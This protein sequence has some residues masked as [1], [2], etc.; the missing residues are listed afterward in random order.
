MAREQQ[1]H[2]GVTCDRCGKAID[3]GE[4][5]GSGLLPGEYCEGCAAVLG[6]ADCDRLRGHVEAIIDDCRRNRCYANI[7]PAIRFLEE[8]FGVKG[9]A[10]P[11]NDP[12]LRMFRE[13]GTPEAKERLMRQLGDAGL[14]ETIVP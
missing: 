1:G 10:L 7:W 4:A 11:R 3:P 8:E 14:G 13:V 6:D 5:G 9:P 2:R 12:R